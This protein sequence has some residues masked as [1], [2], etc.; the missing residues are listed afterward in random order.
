MRSLR[1]I[2]QTTFLAAALLGAATAAGQP[3]A[4]SPAGPAAIDQA[5][6]EEAA[7]EP[8][9]HPELIR[10]SPREEV[11]IDPVRKEVV[12]GGKIALDTGPIEVFACPAG[13]KDHEAIVASKSS[14]KLVHAGLLV[15]G[16]EPGHPASFNPIFQ[17]AEGPAVELRLRWKDAEGKDQERPARELIRDVATGEQLGIDWVF[18]GSH[19]WRNPEDGSQIYQAD[20]GD[21]V[22]VSNFPEAMLDLPIES[23]PTNGELMF[24]AFE[25]RVPPSGTVVEMVLSKKAV[26][27]PAP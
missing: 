7:P 20:G 26:A 8:D 19:C 3:A 2:A 1:T 10:L 27:A 17:P 18:V 24:E 21:M 11:W 6:P 4:D 16:L 25:G 9:R 23:S 22:C 14:A 13:T 5:A 15:I 12:V